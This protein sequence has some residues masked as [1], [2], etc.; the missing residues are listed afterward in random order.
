[1]HQELVSATLFLGAPA[2]L[3]AEK[4]TQSCS[5]SPNKENVYRGLECP[6]R[7]LPFAVSKKFPCP[8]LTPLSTPTPPLSPGMSLVFQRMYFFFFSFMGCTCCIWKFPGYESN[9]SCSCRPTP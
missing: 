1:M 6:G 2:S 3:T 8:Q 9:W 5:S 7:E 4:G